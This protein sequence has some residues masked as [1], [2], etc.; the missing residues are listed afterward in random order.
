MS[1]TKVYRSCTGCFESEDGH[2][3]GNY[4]KHPK[5]RCYVGSGCRECQGRGFVRDHMAEYYA[6][7]SIE[8]I[9]AL[10]NE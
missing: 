6:N 9:T 5:H 2:P 10:L 3:V 8:E 7:M 1:E 4:P